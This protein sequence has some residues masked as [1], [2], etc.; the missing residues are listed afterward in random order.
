MVRLARDN[1][2]GVLL[3]MRHAKY[4][5][6]TPSAMLVCEQLAAER[7]PTEL[8]EQVRRTFP[9]SDAA[10]EKDIMRFLNDLLRRRLCEIC[11]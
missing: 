7:T 10:F 3:D 2:T 5:A 1:D 6:L 11:E 4:F 8:I 9:A